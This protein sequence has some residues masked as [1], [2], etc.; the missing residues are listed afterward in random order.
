MEEYKAHEKLK[1]EALQRDLKAGIQQADQGELLD[2]EE[3]F[4]DLL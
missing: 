2:S 1:L 4:K 3:V